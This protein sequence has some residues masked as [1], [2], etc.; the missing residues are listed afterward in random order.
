[1][2]ATAFLALMGIAVW[3]GKLP[4]L[5]FGSYICLSV[6]SFIAYAADKSAA[7][8]GRW[9]TKENTLHLLSLLGGW[10]GALAAQQI[11]RHKSKKASFRTAFWLTVV[12]N[13]GALGWLLSSPN[14]ALL[15]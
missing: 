13:C 1:M 6:V 8:N 5:L 10:P 3:A 12:V 7:R 15:R 11:L 9:R 2:V 14:I 4:S